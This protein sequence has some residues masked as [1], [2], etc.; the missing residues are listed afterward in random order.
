MRLAQ[1]A[2]RLVRQMNAARALRSSRALSGRPRR[3][4]VE[5]DHSIG[6]LPMPLRALAVRD[7]L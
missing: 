3:Q 4:S 2:H 6:T 5:Q 7:R 1:C